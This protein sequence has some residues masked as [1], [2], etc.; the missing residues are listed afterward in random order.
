MA[1]LALAILVLAL[2]SSAAL[3]VD[4][5]ARAR[6][7]REKYDRVRYDFAAAGMKEEEVLKRL[8]LHP[9]ATQ[10]AVPGHDRAREILTTGAE[11][12]R[13][14]RQMAERL[15]EQGCFYED[16]AALRRVMAIVERLRRQMPALPATQV[17]LAD[18]P[19]FNACCLL[20]GT[21][22]V[23][24]GLLRALK[25]D[26]QLAFVLAHE[27]AHALARHGAEALTKQLIGLAVQGAFGD[28]YIALRNQFARLLPSAWRELSLEQLWRFGIA[29]PYSREMENEADAL[30]LTIAVRAGYRGEAALEF[31]ALLRRFSP[32]KPCFEVVLSDHPTHDERIR[33]IQYLLTRM[34]AWKTP[35][36]K[37]R[38]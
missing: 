17:L 11:E 23:N 4:E 27:L 10:V 37:T 36:P 33:R 19:A 38:R 3:A 21:L 22:V 24:Q 1:R 2:L 9:I 34:Q 31:V 26:D 16:E 7:Y 18:T 29:L 15:R 25:D 6:A 28:A 20:D 5:Q 35:A 14:G 30:G 13:L 32:E 12:R 8:F